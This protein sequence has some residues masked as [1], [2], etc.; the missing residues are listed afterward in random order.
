MIIDATNLILGR[1]ATFVAK[2]ALEGET[3]DVINADKAI[4]TGDKKKVLAEYKRKRDRGSP[5]V[6]PY[7]PRQSDRFVKRTIRGMLPYKRPRGEK[8]FKSIKCHAGVPADLQDQKAETIGSAN[9]IK[10]SNTKFLTV[11]EIC[12]FLGGTIWVN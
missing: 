9:V 7:F 10:L 8:A 4:I 3:I 12:T 6:G 1:L 11:K 2:K 5:L